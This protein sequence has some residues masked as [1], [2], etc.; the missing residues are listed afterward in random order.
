MND[1]KT[2]AAEK[3]AGEAYSTADRE[4]KRSAMR[5]S[6]WLSLQKKH[7]KRH[8]RITPKL[9][10]TTLTLLIKKFQKGNLVKHKEGK[11]VKTDKEVG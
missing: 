9:S 4:V 3:T 8:G 6:L 10:K 7:R 1:S 11:T 5:E 2:R